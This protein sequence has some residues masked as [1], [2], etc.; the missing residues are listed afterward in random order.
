M[1]VLNLFMKINNAK[2]YVWARRCGKTTALI[3]YMLENFTKKRE[4]FT[5]VCVNSNHIKIVEDII[6]TKISWLILNRRWHWFEDSMWNHII[7]LTTMNNG[8]YGINVAV[9]E[10]QKADMNI[11]K[12]Q[13]VAFSWTMPVLKFNMMKT[14]LSKKEVAALKKAYSNKFFD[15]EIL[16]K[17]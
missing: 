12:E 6:L 3:D 17:F 1:D 15:E 9:D 16:C 10:I 7:R 8:S 4:N 2:K 5:F 11:F 13:I 14:T